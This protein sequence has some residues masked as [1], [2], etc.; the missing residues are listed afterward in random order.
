[1]SNSK[2]VVTSTSGTDDI[3]ILSQD[4]AIGKNFASPQGG[5][6]Y[7]CLAVP[8]RLRPGD[9]IR[10]RYAILDTPQNNVSIDPD[11]VNPYITFGYYDRFYD[12]VDRAIAGRS[13]EC[14]ADDLN[15]D[16][17]IAYSDKETADVHTV[18]F[19]YAKPFSWGLFYA[20]FN[21]LDA[22]GNPGSKKVLVPLAEQTPGGVPEYEDVTFD[23]VIT[24]GTL[25][26][27]SPNPVVMQKTYNTIYDP[28]N[29]DITPGTGPLRLDINQ[30]TWNLDS[31]IYSRNALAKEIT[32]QADLLPTAIN[33]PLLESFNPFLLRTD[34][35]N[36]DEI[37][38]LRAT[39][40][41][42]TA[43]DGFEY[44]NVSTNTRNAYWYG[45]SEVSLEYDEDEREI[46]EWTFL[47]TPLFNPASANTPVQNVA[48][49]KSPST[50]GWNSV[51]QASGIYITDMQPRSFWVD[52]LGFDPDKCLVTVIDGVDLDYVQRSDIDIG[53]LA[54]SAKVTKG[55]ITLSSLFPNYDRKIN[56]TGDVIYV[57]VT[58]LSVPLKADQ[59]TSGNAQSHYLVSIKGL[60][61]TFGETIDTGSSMP[62]ICW[63]VPGQNNTND[64]VTG[65]GDSGKTFTNMTLNDIVISEAYVE[66][67]DP[68]TK[69][70]AIGLG[71]NNTIVFDVIRS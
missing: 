10:G 26:L 57:D 21:Y 35:V 40:I 39:E 3:L 29:N 13:R 28:A 43:T 66:I 52:K 11:E 55:P 51:E 16:Y 63:V 49:Y 53:T 67:L 23:T 60:Q 61:F 42:P 45:A 46:F 47:H 2:E 44:Y 14:T 59:P 4:V 15:Y 34:D 48:W 37:R 31:K 50:G 6:W 38:F 68:I 54:S 9:S 56:D 7:E 62:N 27:V 65:Y 24:A 1:M 19:R 17:H 30:F 12:Y 36:T 22:D 41:E 33:Q 58:G 18:R 20:V 5:V 70:P 32:D 8:I 25:Q 64:F 69:S 71:T